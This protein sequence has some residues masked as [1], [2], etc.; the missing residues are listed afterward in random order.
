MS[1]FNLLIFG[2]VVFGL[3][4]IGVVLTILEFRQL[5]REH[6]PAADQQP[7]NRGSDQ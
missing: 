6:P 2:I 7:V 1:D 3:M 5:S 4:L